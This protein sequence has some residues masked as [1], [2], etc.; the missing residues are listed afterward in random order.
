M[1]QHPLEPVPASE[2]GLMMPLDFNFHRS[3]KN[4]PHK[5]HLQS[6]SNDNLQKVATDPRCKPEYQL[7]P[8]TLPPPEQ[9]IRLARIKEEQDSS[10]NTNKLIED[11]NSRCEDIIKEQ[12][13]KILELQKALELSNEQ[14]HARNNVPKPTGPFLSSNGNSSNTKLLLAQ[15]IQ[16][17]QLAAQMNHWAMQDDLHQNTTHQRQHGEHFSMNEVA[18]SILQNKGKTVRINQGQ[19]YLYP[20]IFRGAREH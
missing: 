10:D 1:V 20:F 19:I 2:H 17:K 15:Q 18:E 14:L 4:H 16:S 13:D 8:A 7:L 6:I 11:D 9:S 12:Q 3:N 5:G